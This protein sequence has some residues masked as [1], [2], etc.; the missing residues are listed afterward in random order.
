M[1]LARLFFSVA[2]LA[3][4][5]MAAPPAFGLDFDLETARKVFETKCAHCHGL[6]RPLKKT[7]SRE[8][9]RKTIERMRSH[10][11]GAISEDDARIILEYLQR[12]RG[13]KP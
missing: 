3:S 10:S 4:A 12:V 6:D 13:P 1:G 9:W 8:G 2:L 11:Q 7:K 5:P